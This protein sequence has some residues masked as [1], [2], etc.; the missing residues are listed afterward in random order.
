MSP[1]EKLLG[2]QRLLPFIGLDLV[3]ELQWVVETEPEQVRAKTAAVTVGLQK[4]RA[5]QGKTWQ[6]C[7]G[8]GGAWPTKKVY[9]LGPEL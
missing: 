9:K 5:M 2:I 3:L 6:D 1:S 4:K 8:R 7:L